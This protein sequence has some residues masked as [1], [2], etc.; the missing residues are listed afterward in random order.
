MKNILVVGGGTGG[1]L[2]ANLLA[3]RLAEEIRKD[4]VSVTLVSDKPEHVFQPSNLDVAFKGSKPT[5]YIRKQQTLLNR[6]VVFVNEKAERIDLNNRKLITEK[7]REISYDYIVIATGSVADPTLTPGLA[8]AGLNFHTTP[9]AAEEIWKALQRFEGGRVVLVI[10]G[11]PHKCP[12]APTEAMFLLDDYFRKRGIREKVELSFLTPYP[13]AYPAKPIAEVVQP[14]LEK[15]NVNITTFFNLESVNPV[16]KTV[17]SLEGEEVAYD[18]L[19]AV[20]PHR[21]AEVVLRSEIGDRDGWIPADKHTMMVGSFDDAYAV[22]DATNIPIS[23]SGVVAHIQSG[24]VAHN[25]VAKVRGDGSLMKYNGRINCP[26]EVGGGKALFVSGTYT[27]PPEPMK[28]T[29]IRYWM[30]KGFSRLY[31]AMLKG[32]WEPLFDLYFR[33]KDGEAR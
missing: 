4:E 14:L 24:I 23:K 16:K 9:W 21:G 7:G 29:R 31:W 26:L 25:I 11:V 20:P 30:K 32:G 1:T 3:R 19:I 6:K 17:S 33:E 10:A 27:R 12:P 22:G 8:E 2:T 5:N 18:L 13:H 15:R 28:P